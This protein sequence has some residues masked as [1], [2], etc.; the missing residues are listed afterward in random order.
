MSD[1]IH[2]A[3]LD[4]PGSE[5][6]RQLLDALERHGWGV[7][8][9]PAHVTRR[10]RVPTAD[11]DRLAEFSAFRLGYTLTPP[12]DI[13]VQLGPPTTEPLDATPE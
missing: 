7:N 13:E 3:F 8:V 11:G 9:Q 5:E 10:A 1:T 6:I 4:E 12:Q 2:R